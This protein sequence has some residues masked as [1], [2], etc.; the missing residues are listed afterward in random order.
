MS[1]YGRYYSSTVLARDGSVWRQPAALSGVV[2]YLD[3][4]EPQQREFWTVS[5]V[6][7]R[8]PTGSVCAL[9]SLIGLARRYNGILP[10]GLQLYPRPHSGPTI[11]WQFRKQ[12][13]AYPT[14]IQ[15]QQL[16]RLPK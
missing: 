12:Q 3:R 10:H 4:Y 9:A 7:K 14:D 2:P 1:H 11:A 13:R 16:Q 6:R 8:N 5:Q 15:L